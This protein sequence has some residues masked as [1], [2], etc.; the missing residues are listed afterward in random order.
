MD[1][2]GSRNELTQNMNWIS[3][4]RTSNSKVDKTPNKMTIA[5]RIR[6]RLAIRRSEV[7]IELH[8]SLNSTLISERGAIKKIL[9]YFSW[10]IKKPF[11]V[12]VTSIP[13]K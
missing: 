3:D 1:L 6:K 9:I 2:S 5:S 10:D 12:E 7:N 11:G 4:I 13:R 8:G